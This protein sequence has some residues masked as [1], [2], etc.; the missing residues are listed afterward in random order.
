VT[1]EDIESEAR[2][3]SDL[4][5]KG[6]CLFVVEVIKHAW[7]PRN[8]LYYYIDM[9]YCQLTLESYI[10]RSGR[11]DSAPSLAKLPTQDVAHSS[12]TITNLRMKYEINTSTD[13]DMEIDWRAVVSIVDD[14]ARALVYVHSEGTVHRD[15]KPRNGTSGPSRLLIV[16]LYSEKDRCWKLA[17][18]GTASKATSK[19][20]NTTS[21]SRGTAGYR[22]PE[23]LDMTAPKFNNKADIF[24]FG[25]IIYEI[26][27]GQKL[28]WDDFAI[29]T[30]AAS[31]VVSSTI[32]WPEAAGETEHKIASLEKLVASLLELDALKRPNASNIRNELFRIRLNE[33]DE[34]EPMTGIPIQV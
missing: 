18:F 17:D 26:V 13:L 4:C 7:F 6:K 9:E 30:Y 33:I 28:F 8:S 12:G 11:S 20:L 10:H 31:G 19:R 21:Y 23:I 22:A 27:T 16:V 1:K 29:I 3:V 32:M 15:L 25:C 2:V 14:I 24:A 34:T 5:Q